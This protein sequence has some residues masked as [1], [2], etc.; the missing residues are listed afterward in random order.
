MTAE[1]VIRALVVKQLGSFSYEQLAFHLT[2]SQTYRT[3]CRFG[4]L[5][6]TLRAQLEH[7]LELTRRVAE[8]T[9]RR[10]FLGE[11][12][13]AAEKIV[14]IFEPHVDIIRKGSRDTV[15]GH[16]VYLTVG[17]SLILDVVVRSGNPADA[18][19]VGTMIDRHAARWGVPPKQAVFDGGFTSQ[20]NLE[21]LKAAGVEDVVFTR[22]RRIA[23]DEMA[24]SAWVY[25]QLRRFRAGI[26]GVIGYLKMAYGLCRVT[27]RGLARFR[28]YVWASVVS[29]NLMTLARHR[30]AAA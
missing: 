9:E 26:E 25:R 10:G 5:D 23:V 20:A 28:T 6:G 21:E 30:M 4:A 24:K 12:V 3:F 27:W 18:T 8:Q 17:E 29:A 1:Q 19:T 15:F 13:P 2:D 7:Y 11:S 14:S 22:A 16:K